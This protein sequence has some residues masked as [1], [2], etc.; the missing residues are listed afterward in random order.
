MSV[1][2]RR[3]GQST[4]V[5]IVSDANPSRCARTVH[6]RID[7]GANRPG[8]NRLGGELTMGRIVRRA[9]RPWGESSS[10]WAKRP[11]GETQS[12]RNVL[13]PNKQGE[14]MEVNN[15]RWRPFTGSAHAWIQVYFTMSI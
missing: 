5:R 15:E 4:M 2:K 1:A 7:N 14:S 10:V 12:G 9:N 13:L 11:W 3:R 8:A 6:G